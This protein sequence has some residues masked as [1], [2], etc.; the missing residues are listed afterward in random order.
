[1]Q[2]KKHHLDLRRAIRHV[3]LEQGVPA[4]SIATSSLC[5]ACRDDLFFSY[6][7]DSRETGRMA[8]VFWKNEP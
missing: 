4:A 6:R 7:R 5:T 8:A 1:M 2:G 3:L